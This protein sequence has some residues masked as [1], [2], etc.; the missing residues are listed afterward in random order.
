MCLSCWLLSPYFLCRQVH[1]SIDIWMMNRKKCGVEKVPASTPNRPSALPASQTGAWQSLDSTLSPKS[2]VK[3]NDLC[4]HTLRR[5]LLKKNIPIWHPSH[6]LPTSDFPHH[7]L[8][9]RD[10]PPAPPRAS[11]WLSAKPKQGAWDTCLGQCK[12]PP[13]MCG[14]TSSIQMQ[15]LLLGANAGRISRDQ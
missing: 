14:H 15:W 10:P 4:K 1:I 5:S 2:H 7:I 12:L 11:K 8:H 6:D 3:A 9:L 13:G